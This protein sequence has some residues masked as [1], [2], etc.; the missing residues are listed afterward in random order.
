[1]EIKEIVKSN[2]KDAYPTRN[3]YFIKKIQ[4][5]L[6]K[7]GWLRSSYFSKNEIVCVITYD[8]IYDMDSVNLVL[9]TFS[10]SNW[11]MKLHKYEKALSPDK[12]RNWYVYTFCIVKRGCTE[13]NPNAVGCW[14]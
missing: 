9:R 10:D 1:M 4:D 8:Y 11:E 5:S 7:R 13:N 12:I 2:N 14:R 6:N 3:L